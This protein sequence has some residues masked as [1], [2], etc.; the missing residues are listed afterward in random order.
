LPDSLDHLGTLKIGAEDFLAAVLQTMAQPIWVVDHAGLIRFANPAAVAALGYGAATE[1]LGRPSHETIHYQHPDGSAYPAAD[2]PMLL[3]RATGEKVARDLDWFF[4]RD[5]SMF[6]VSYVS[7]PLEM[8][9]GRGAVVAF[10]DIEER[11]RAERMLKERDAVLAAQQAALRRVA[12]LVAGGAASGEVFASIAREVARVLGLAMVWVWRYEPDG[13]ATVL[14]SWSERPHPFQ[15]GTRW[16]ID[17]PTITALVKQT[18]RPVR[19]DDFAH[20]PGTIADA[21]RD[22]GI[23]SG[24]GAPIIVDGN[25]WGVMATGMVTGPHGREPLP[26]YIE[27]RLAQFTELVATAISTTAGREQLAR[28]AHEQSALRRVATLVARESPLAEIFTAV[29]QELTRLLD[30]PGVR[31]IR[32]EDDG[33]AT[34]VGDWGPPDFT[35]PLGTRLPLGG[36][37]LPTMVRR[38]GRCARIDDFAAD[39]SGSIGD[40]AR[41]LGVRAGVGCPIVV[42]GRLWGCILAAWQE[43]EPLPAGTE[44]RIEEFTSLMATA[45]ANTNARSELAASR[46]RIMAATDEERRRVVRDL[47]DGAQQR[48]VHTVITLDRAREALRSQQGPGLEL[49]SEALGHARQATAELRELSYGILPGVLTHD[50]LRAGVHALASRMRVPVENGVV[51]GRFPAAVEATAYFV[52]AEALTNVAKHAG[53]QHAA[54]T[55]QVEDGTLLICVRDDGDGGARPDGNGLQG[56]ADRLAVLG[57]RLR[58]ESPA[59]GGTLL[60]A[61]IPLPD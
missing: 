10:T 3:P 20:V 51:S 40:Y 34:Y 35:F 16:P 12:T 38:T 41:G 39:A 29:A 15:A 27:D 42:E 25:V 60:T 30:I 1:L 46:A 47:H 8:P 19:I 17:G 56:L 24:A 48:L 5:G 31:I 36:E 37:N 18:G 9:K 22:A 55:A 23:R 14:G 44:R 13:R 28:L 11:L 4:R 59:D 43:A 49:V 45:I 58:V 21:V 33:D 50:G 54:V 57:G 53:A 52:V 32:Y 6:P 61:T 2:C 26:N 7:V